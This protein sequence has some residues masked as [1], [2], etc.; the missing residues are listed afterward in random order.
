[1]EYTRLMMVF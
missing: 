1:V